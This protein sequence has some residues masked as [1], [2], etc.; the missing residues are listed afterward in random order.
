MPDSRFQLLDAFTLQVTV[1]AHNCSRER[2]KRRHYLLLAFLAVVTRGLGS[3]TSGW[4]PLVSLLAWSET[5]SWNPS[6]SRTAGI[7]L[8]LQIF[9]REGRGEVFS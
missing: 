2:P 5:L 7:L 6:P 9:G 4:D 1:G 8:Y 3:E